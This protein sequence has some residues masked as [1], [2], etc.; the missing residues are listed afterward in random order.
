MI[1]EVA[2]LMEQVLL[3]RFESARMERPRFHW[4]LRAPTGPLVIW[5]FCW[6]FHWGPVGPIWS[7][8]S[9]GLLIVGIAGLWFSALSVAELAAWGCYLFRGQDHESIINPH[10]SGPAVPPKSD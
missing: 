6:L 9:L 2:H 7:L 3:E 4:L 1:I 8:K 5:G 10:D